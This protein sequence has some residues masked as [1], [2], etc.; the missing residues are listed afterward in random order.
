MFVGS[1][2]ADADEFVCNANIATYTSY[3]ACGGGATV[4]NLMLMGV[5]Q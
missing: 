4:R 5:G 1:S 3:A 2:Y